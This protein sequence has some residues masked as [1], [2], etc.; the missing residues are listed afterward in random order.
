MINPVLFDT[1]NNS[2]AVKAVLGV[3]LRVYPWGR[4]PQNV[5]KPYATYDVY[6]AVPENYLGNR[7]DIDNKG[8]Q[9]QIFS[10]DT[11][12]LDACFIA[13][14]DAIEPVAHITSFQTIARDDDTD[15][16]SIILDIDFWES[17]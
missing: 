6:N 17:R 14:R 11:G 7:P 5:R 2:N 4:A 13:V 9:L 12:K 10:D 3:P 15:L 8:T 1:L 16:Y